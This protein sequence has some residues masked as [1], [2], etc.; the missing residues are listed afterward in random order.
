MR[1]LMM[2]A[3]ACG[4]TLLFAVPAQAQLNGSHTPGDFGVQSG[5]QPQ[6]G[7]YAAL[8]Y[9]RYDA[10]TIKDA[11]GNVVR[12]SPSAPGSLAVAAAAPLAWYVSKAKI[13]GANYGAMAVL[14]F[15]NASIEAPAFALGKTIDTSVSDLLLRPIDLGWHTPRAD[16]SAG[17]QLY[18]PTGRYE[19]GGSDNIGKGMWTYEPFVGTTVYF[20]QKRTVSLAATAYW[21]F[22]G[23]KKDTDVKV[24]QILTLQG[25]FAKSFLGGGLITGA[26]YYAQ[27]KLTEDQLAE[28]QLPGDLRST[29]TSPA[30][31]ASTRSG[32][33]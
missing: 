28:F 29:S 9:L 31:T 21:E 25:G 1:R 15:A 12:L 2:P 3:I 7:F 4:L 6:P 32:R 26:A 16:V 33:T 23:K 5:S 10:D 30:S 14:P 19:R 20:D 8:F 24:G 18:A 17:F 11:D 13:L 22:H 27:W